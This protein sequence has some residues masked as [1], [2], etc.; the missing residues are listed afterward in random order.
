MILQF[1]LK[2]N[3]VVYDETKCEELGQEAD[4][5]IPNLIVNF[6]FAHLKCIL[7]PHKFLKLS[8][9]KMIKLT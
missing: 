8:Q 9:Y 4:K 2:E 3:K 6:L 5:K 1:N 7:G